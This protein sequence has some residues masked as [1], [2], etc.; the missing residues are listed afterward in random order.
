MSGRRLIGAVLAGGRG[1]RLG[2]R[3]KALLE[4]DGVPL[5][6]RALAAL[7]DGLPAG[8]GLVVSVADAAQRARLVATVSVPATFV[9]DAVPDAGPLAGILA[10][11]EH[12][13]AAGA[14][15]V[16]VLAADMPRVSA[17]LVTWLAATEPG[18]V[19]LV[20]RRAGKLEPLCA[21]YATSLAPRVAARLSL[22]RRAVC[23][24]VDDVAAARPDLDGEPE[25]LEALLDVDTEE[26]AA[27][28]GILVPA[29][30]RPR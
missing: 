5:L 23:G 2:G 29:D 20:P 7:R 25:L 13:A 15:D 8:A 27:M 1:R 3:T 12:G 17:R 30:R 26:D 9:L 16:V 10:C 21:R 11:L 22:G 28:A 6:A 14:T 19:A 24:L 4:L 18:A